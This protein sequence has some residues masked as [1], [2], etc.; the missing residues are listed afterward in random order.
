M[1]V[2]SIGRLA[3]LVGVAISLVGGF[4]LATTIFGDDPPSGT[5]F[6]RPIDPPPFESRRLTP[7]DEEFA[8]FPS[9][10]DEFAIYWVG[11][12]FRGLPL[13]HIVRYVSPPDAIRVENKVAFL[14]GECEMPAEGGCPPPLQIII[15]PYCLVPPSLI[16][17]APGASTTTEIRGT[18]TSREAGGG[19]R[20][21]TGGVTVK[22]YASS[23]SL[24]EEATEELRSPNGLGPRDAGDPLPVP[25]AD[26]SGYEMAPLP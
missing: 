4:F 10:F 14:Y 7:A 18:A 25:A 17:Q 22:V 15:E 19:L 11:D 20:I 1:Q 13:R 23:P 26:C 6:P 5:E 24:L 21:W 3:I 2:L 9:E 16:D 12:E 8:L